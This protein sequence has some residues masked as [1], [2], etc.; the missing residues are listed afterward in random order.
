MNPE[1][2]ES[3]RKSRFLSFI[4]RNPLAAEAMFVAGL[5]IVAIVVALAYAVSRSRSSDQS[6]IR[7]DQHRAICPL[8]KPPEPSFADG[9]RFAQIA[10]FNQPGIGTFDQLFNV[11][12]NWWFEIQVCRG[13]NVMRVLQQQ[14]AQEAV[15]QQLAAKNPPVVKTNENLVGHDPSLQS[16]NPPIQ[17]PASAGPTA[18]RPNP[19]VKKVYKEIESKPKDH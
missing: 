17:Q 7:W 8:L 4:S 15:R 1:N 18:D 5:F 14:A 12:S 19:P 10:L 13:T 16:T 9:A 3:P 6:D 2:P 11:S